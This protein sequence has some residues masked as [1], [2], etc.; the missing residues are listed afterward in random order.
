MT[1]SDKPMNGALYALSLTCLIQQRGVEPRNKSQQKR[2]CYARPYDGVNV[3]HNG[4]K[5]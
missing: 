5:R 2:L 3:N 1:A 4:N